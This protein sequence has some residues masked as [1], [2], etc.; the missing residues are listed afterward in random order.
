MGHDIEALPDTLVALRQD[1]RNEPTYY[2]IRAYLDWLSAYLSVQT[3][4]LDRVV[5]VDN[6]IDYDALKRE[7]KE[8]LYAQLRKELYD[9]LRTQ[10]HTE[11]TEGLTMQLSEWLRNYIETQ[12]RPRLRKE[13]ER[14]LCDSLYQRLYDALYDAL[15]ELLYKPETQE[16]DEFIPLI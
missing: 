12:L 14:A 10:L 4:L 6:S 3:E 16:E 15:S 2:H 9:E 11:L 5:L 13:I 7:I 8:E 1:V